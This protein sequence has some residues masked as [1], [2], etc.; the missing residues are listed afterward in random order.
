ML[1][2]L[3]DDSNVE[4]SET[5]IVPLVFYSDPGHAVSCTVEGRVLLCLNHNV[6]LGHDWL[7]HVN[8]AI[9]W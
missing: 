2:T 3:A 7:Q 9:N 4:A 8:P 5:C 6:V 1:V